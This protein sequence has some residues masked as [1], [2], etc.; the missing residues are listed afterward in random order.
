MSNKK[1]GNREV[2]KPKKDSQKKKEKKDP[3]RHDTIGQ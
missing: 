1:N 2:K 3:N